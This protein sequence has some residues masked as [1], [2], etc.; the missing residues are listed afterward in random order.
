MFKPALPPG[1][2][3]IQPIDEK[4]RRTSIRFAADVTAES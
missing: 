4:E 2:M 3:D 1:F